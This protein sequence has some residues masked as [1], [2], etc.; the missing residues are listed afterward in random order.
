MIQSSGRPI[1]LEA[2][3]APGQPSPNITGQIVRVAVNGT[4]LGSVRIDGRS[5][6]RTEIDPVL[7]CQNGVLK[8]EFGFPG[9]HRP[10]LACDSSDERPLSCWFSFVRVYTLDM[11][12]PGPWFPTSHPDIPI[13]RLLP[14]FAVPSDITTE[15]AHSL[16]T[17]GGA[18]IA[19]P[20]QG[21]G[22]DIGVDKVT[23]TARSGAQLKLPAP[24]A[25]G[26]YALRLDA[27]PVMVP[28]EDSMRDV[29]ILLDGIVVGQIILREPST[30]F[31]PLP[32]ELTEWQDALRLNFVLWD[33]RPPEGPGVANEM[34]PPGIT[35]AS[36]GIPRL[37]SR[38]APA[39]CLRAEQ[40]GT[41]PPMATSGEFLNDDVMAV[42]AGIRAALGMDAVTLTRGF[43][44]LGTSHELGVV[45]RK[46]GLDVVNLFGFCEATVADLTRALTDD[47]MAASD[48]D[49]VT[50]KASDTDP[51]CTY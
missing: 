25:P 47:L 19:Q 37:P 7:I 50:I 42:P 51:G 12:K 9:F 43:E 8:I 45:Q 32:R 46:L 28:G 18:G 30:W 33:A 10:D 49:L 14:P 16:Y 21:D 2:E 39:E 23:S 38:F 13:V 6:V 36:I 41:P 20:F 29:T 27:F 22:W 4:N 15:A 31:L 5:M 40:A 34:P 26:F 17:F 24:Q 1:V 3:L 11:F 48:P 35:V 44:S